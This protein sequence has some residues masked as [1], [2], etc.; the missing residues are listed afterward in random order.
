MTRRINILLALFLSLGFLANAQETTS[1]I[2][3]IVIDS[4]GVALAGAT[5][6]ATHTPT[7]TKYT[8][9]SRKDGRYNL[10]NLRIGGPYVITE[11]FVGHKPQTQENISLS[12]GQV[13][14]VDFSADDNLTELSTVVVNAGRH[15][16]LIRCTNVTLVQIR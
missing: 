5:I 6:V 13:F 10:A 4:K 14:K 12:L 9:S 2:Q 8:T 1:E 11:S 7:G 15:R 3:G 16:Y